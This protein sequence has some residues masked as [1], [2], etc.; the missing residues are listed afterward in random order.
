MGSLG[1]FILYF[2]DTDK[3]KIDIAEYLD[4]EANE[5]YSEEQR[6][7]AKHNLDTD[8]APEIVKS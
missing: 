1:A 6:A 4:R 7:Q 5:L 3:A 2:V 8:E